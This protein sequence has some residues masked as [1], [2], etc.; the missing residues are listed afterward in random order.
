MNFYMPMSMF[1]KVLVGA[2]AHGISADAATFN[3]FGIDPRLPDF[4]AAADIHG[5]PISIG[6]DTLN[7]LMHLWSDNLRKHHPRL[8]IQVLGKGSTAAAPPLISGM[9]KFGPMNRLM[10]P[11][12]LHAF[13]K[14][15]GYEPTPLHVANDTL[16]IFVHKNNPIAKRGLTIAQID[17]IFSSTRKRGYPRDITTWGDLGLKDDWKDE[18]IILHG[19]N[20]ASGSYGWFKKSALLRGAFKANVHQSPGSALIAHEISRDRYA[21]GYCRPPYFRGKEQHLAIVPIRKPV[22]TNNAPKKKPD[23]NDAK[24]TSPFY[25]T[26]NGSPLSR[27]LYIYIN[28]HRRKNPLTPPVREFF[29]LVYS[30]QGQLQVVRDGYIPL[31]LETCRA[32]AKK[33]GIKFSKK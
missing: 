9:S 11:N 13:K 5:R 33:I 1:M 21:I 18:P 4:M 29:R 30:K 20:T 17:A 28:Y 7:N 27:P 12:E 10:K 24:K 19:R 6:S 26:I 14:K 23:K 22:T 25:D 16:A 2:P 15:H 3:H 31:L 32:E 8:R